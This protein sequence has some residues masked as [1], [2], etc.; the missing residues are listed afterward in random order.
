MYTIP[1]EIAS[2]RTAA[3]I[4]ATSLF[5][6]TGKSFDRNKIIGLVMEKFEENYEKFIQ[7]CDLSLMT[8]DYNKLL[9]NKGKQVRI[10]DK[11]N[12]FEGTALGI[13]E[14]GELLVQTGAE[15]VCAVRAG[16][17]SVRGLYSYV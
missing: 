12:P 16:E 14:T 2:F 11:N 3:G 1:K 7:T 6:E 8:E 10:I 5:L 4:K 17:V 9:A 13:N 15:E